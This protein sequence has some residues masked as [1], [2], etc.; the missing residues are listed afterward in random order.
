[1]IGNHKIVITNALSSEI[2][3]TPPVRTQ[4]LSTTPIRLSD[5]YYYVD[6]RSEVVIT[7]N[8]HGIT[9]IKFTKP[10]FISFSTT[11]ILVKQNGEFNRV[12]LDMLVRKWSYRS[13]KLVYQN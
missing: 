9:K 7:H 4:I 12:L 6:D 3:Y 8:E 5:N 10:T 11:D 2:T 13:F 1:V